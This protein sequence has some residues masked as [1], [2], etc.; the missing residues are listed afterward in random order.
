MREPGIEITNVRAGAAR[1]ITV[2]KAA[3]DTAGEDG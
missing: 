2:R 1:L 3:Q